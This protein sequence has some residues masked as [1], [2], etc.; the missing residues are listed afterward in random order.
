MANI[1]DSEEE[2]V[3]SHEVEDPDPESIG[4]DMDC[5]ECSAP[6]P[7]GKCVEGCGG[8]CVCGA[9]ILVGKCAD[10]CE[11]WQALQKRR[12]RYRRQLENNLE[13]LGMQAKNTK[14]EPIA[15]GLAKPTT[16]SISELLELSPEAC[17]S[18]AKAR[19]APFAEVITF[20]PEHETFDLVC[21]KGPRQH[22]DPYW[23]AKCD[24]SSPR[25]LI[26]WLA[27]LSEKQW[28]TPMHIAGLVVLVDIH[29]GLYELYNQKK[30][31][32]GT[33]G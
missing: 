2:R 12:K 30:K 4:E 22:L 6:A 5:D 25:D 28:V 13:K 31:R 24:I 3:L 27:H 32:T 16:Y 14:L 20:D 1:D 8:D 18:Q 29:V 26:K 9:P 23:I 21:H 15:E 7:F 11:E 33:V 17:E 19:A 10:E